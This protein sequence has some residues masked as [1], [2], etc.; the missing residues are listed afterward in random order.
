M[1]LSYKVNQ[2]GYIGVFNAIVRFRLNGK[3]SHNELAFPPDCGADAYM[4]DGSCQPDAN[5]AIWCL[6]SAATDI[7][8]KWSTKRAG[9]KGG[10]RFKR[11]V[12]HPEKWDIVPVDRRHYETA[13]IWGVVNSGLSY[14]WRLILGFIAWPFNLFKQRDSFSTCSKAVASALGF[15]DA[16][17]FDPCVL[18]AAVGHRE[19]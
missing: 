19:S 5:G 9:K 8:P 15:Q 2:D 12:I 10:V 17:R 6:S 18:H 7:I 16:W 1:L 3:Y 13:A 14:D 11:I 4:P